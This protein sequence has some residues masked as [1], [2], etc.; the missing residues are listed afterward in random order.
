[1]IER[2][3]PHARQAGA[4]IGIHRGRLDALPV[5][6]TGIG[7]IVVGA[8]GGA[9]GRRHLRDVLA[10]PR[11]RHPHDVA[12]RGARAALGAWAVDHTLGHQRLVPDGR[13]VIVRVAE[14]V[15]VERQM[16][17]AVAPAVGHEGH[18]RVQSHAVRELRGQ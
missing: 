1:M 10:E 17:R 4:R 9:V 8:L 6:G 7:G 2:E 18:A 3:P 15:V 14:D 13:A 5:D 11:R 12:R 16:S